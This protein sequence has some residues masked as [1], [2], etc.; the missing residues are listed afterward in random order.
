MSEMGKMQICPKL[1]ALL[2]ILH[3]DKN[4][5]AAVCVQ[6]LCR[7]LTGARFIRQL[8]KPKVLQ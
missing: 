5:W 8:T 4:V 3:K 6:S 2:R 7:G 1:K